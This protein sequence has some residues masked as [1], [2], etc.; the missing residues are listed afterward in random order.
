MFVMK[1]NKSFKKW[2][3]LGL[4]KYFF[5]K[6]MWWYGDVVIFD[7][8]NILQSV[9][10]KNSNFV[11]IN[12]Q[13]RKLKINNANLL[14]TKNKSNSIVITLNN[15][16]TFS[17]LHLN[18]KDDYDRLLMILAINTFLFNESIIDFEYYDYDKFDSNLFRKNKMLNHIRSNYESLLID[19]YNVLYEDSVT[20]LWLKKT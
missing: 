7:D 10:N 17:K 2:N 13:L 8:E 11:D 18:K 9:Y 19:E 3:A 16:Y 20:T 1:E 6:G 4:E 12:K 5:M 14:C 15:D